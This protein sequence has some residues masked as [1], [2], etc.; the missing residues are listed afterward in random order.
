[1]PVLL[2]TLVVLTIGNYDSSGTGFN[3]TSTTTFTPTLSGTKRIALRRGSVSQ[4]QQKATPGTHARRTAST[5]ERERPAR[6][7]WDG[8]ALGLRGQRVRLELDRD[9]LLD[10]PAS[11]PHHG[12]L[13]DKVAKELAHGGDVSRLELDLVAEDA[14][15]RPQNLSRWNGPRCAWDN[16]IFTL[17]QRCDSNV[18]ALGR[19]GNSYS[20]SARKRFVRS[21][22]GAEKKRSGGASSITWPSSIIRI[23]L[24]T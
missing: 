16:G 9:A 2:L 3:L 15:F 22:L 12:A 4:F 6:G 13:D 20:T 11:R 1:M 23:E 7:R 18:T 17:R 10:R 8:L 19:N 5:A 21:W 24:A 14:A